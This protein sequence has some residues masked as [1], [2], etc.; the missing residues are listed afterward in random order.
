MHFSTKKNMHNF[1]VLKT[2]LLS[3]ILVI[4]SDTSTESTFNP[5]QKKRKKIYR[6]DFT[7]TLELF[8]LVALWKACTTCV[9]LQVGFS[10]YFS[11]DWE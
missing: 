4:N 8:G 9:L 5:V 10:L 11:R 2:I 1:Q 3:S 7:F 6:D